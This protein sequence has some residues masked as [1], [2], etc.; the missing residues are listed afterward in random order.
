M[1]PI[2]CKELET[3]AVAL[4]WQCVGHKIDP[5]QFG[6]VKGSSTV[7]ALVE[8][9]HHCY[10]ET[11]GSDKFARIL[12]LDYTKAFDLINH[13]ILMEKLEKLEVPKF[14]LKWIAMFL[15][16][17]KQQVR[18][19]NHHSS[20]LTLQGGVPQ[21]T[22]LGPVLF[23]LMINDLHPSTCMTFKY[24][25]D[26]T[27]L[28]TNTDPQSPNLQTAANEALEW[29][30]K[31]DMQINP[32][33]TKEILIDFSITKFTDFSTISVCG[34]DI[35]RVSEAKA[36][37]VIISEDLK[38][39]SHIDA[40]T[41]KAGQRIH[42]LTQMKRA[43]VPSDDIVMMYCAKI[44]PILEYACQVW[45]PGLTDYLA[46]D[47]ERIQ[48]RAL[49]VIYPEKSYEESLNLTKLTTL[50]ERRD[51]ACRAFVKSMKSKDHKLHHLIPNQKVNNYTMRR[52]MNYEPPKL[53][54]YRAKGSLINWYLCNFK[55][56]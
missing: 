44:R 24:V 53:K 54:T 21:G 3:H 50:S 10:H 37:G 11:D 5:K 4:L 56:E 33:K 13:Q 20:W 6:T 42:M 51:Q 16:E 39:N 30:R 2:L 52:P 26:T 17:R 36:L 43:G 9:M 40:V 41:S 29:S 1:T 45:H 47:I 32:P 48:K 46:K 15:T 12:L 34:E 19:G 49:W 25:D 28:D 35:V 38:W 22:K 27:L 14:L 31:N 55:D 23:I 7:H 18:I 8:L